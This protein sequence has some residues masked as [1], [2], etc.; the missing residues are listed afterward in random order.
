[1][2]EFTLNQG[3]YSVRITPHGTG[4]SS[5]GA[6]ALN[7]WSGDRLIDEQGFFLYLRD[8]E[9]SKA[10][11]ATPKPRMPGAGSHQGSSWPD[12][13]RWE[14][15]F[16]GTETR[17]D[18][19]CLANG[20]GEVR[21]LEVTNR[22]GGIREIE[23]TSFLEV[24]LHHPEAD[25]NHPAFQKLF[26]QTERDLGSSALLAHRR[27]RAQDESWPWLIHRLEGA[28][29]TQWETSR[30][31]F[32]GRG[33]DASN[34][35]ALQ[36]DS[37]LSNLTGKVLDACFSLRC[38][39]TLDAGETRT[40]SFLLG[41]AESREEA[42]R[43]TGEWTEPR[44]AGTPFLISPLLASAT[45]ERDGEATVPEA[46]MGALRNLSG[47]GGFAPDGNEYVIR[48]PWEHGQPRRTPM[49]WSNCIANQRIGMLVTESGSVCTWA[50]NSQANRLTP[51]SNDPVTDPHGEALY[52]R[53]EDTGEFWSPL[54]GPAPVPAAY[55]TRHG[56]GYSTF[57][58][59]WR[60]SSSEIDFFVPSSMPVR[61]V[62]WRLTNQGKGA[63]RFGFYG[64]QRLVLGTLPP[65]PGQLRV[66]LFPRQA[67]MTVAYPQSSP[68]AGPEVFATVLV[69]D[70]E[71]G[72][73]SGTADRA[74]FLGRD[75]G[76]MARPA[77][78]R[79]TGP[80][81]GEAGDGADACFGQRVEVEVEPGAEVEVTFL[82]GECDPGNGLGSLPSL[83]HRFR[84]PGAAATMLA[85]VKEVWRSMLGGIQV[86]T[87]V[88]S[89]D[90]MLNGWLSYQAIASRLIGR[91]AFY[92]SSGAYGFRDQLQDAHGLSMLW[93]ALTRAQIVRNA[94]QQ[95]GEGDVMHWWHPEPISRG[96][97]TRFSDDLLWLPYVTASYAE[98]T[99][100]SSIWE[101]EIPFL[102][103][104]ELADGQDE[105]Y[106]DAVPSGETGTI[107]EHCCRAIDRSLRTGRHGLP[108][109]GTGD[110]NDGMN[111]VGR[112]GK[113]ESIWMAFFLAEVLRRMVP[114]CE[115]RNEL[116]RAREYTKH[117]E[118][119]AAAVEREG[120]DG[121]WYRRAY[122]DNGTPLG[123]AESPECQIDS[124]A[125]SWAVIS[126][127]GD[128]ARAKQGMNSAWERLLVRE[129]GLVRL[130]SPPFVS[131]PEDPGYIKGY[132]AGVR[133]NGGQYTHAA[134]WFVQA[135]AMAG[136][137]DDAAEVL[138][139]LTPV[140]HTR[141]LEATERYMVEPYVIAADVYDGDPLT[142]RGGWTWYTG[143]AAW[144]YRVA[145][146]TVLG[147]RIREGR[148]L[149]L[150]PRV[151]SSWPGFELR[152]RHGNRGTVY[153]IQANRRATQH[154]VDGRILEAADDGL[155]ISIQDDGR[156]HDVE[157]GLSIFQEP[158]ESTRKT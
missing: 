122:Y 60:D 121:E 15:S 50:R 22:S 8:V 152:Y 61:V 5:L 107:F 43:L 39:L 29:V 4:Q 53:D 68:F 97:R 81:G 63:R 24:V 135:L 82:L 90:L 10:W 139:W 92:Q 114:W 155:T 59:A 6:V 157:L 38:L 2:R 130:L 89:L 78:L 20:Q 151:P 56:W 100:D 70:A 140:W 69:N 55:E 127:I 34:P 105:A 95:F 65:A 36:G 147:F 103:G 156:S 96:M 31:R 145:L 35:R 57:R 133:E 46:Y 137:T 28:P 19:A 94:R 72:A 110:W 120:W 158:S 66:K 62:R 104:Q 40:L 76:G 48:L 17:L 12:R 83:L 67:V 102:Q 119:L 37:N 132:V 79:E 123:S 85:E 21:R 47:Y 75:G 54:P 87:P 25:A 98:Q 13:V 45:A 52:L 74:A 148:E 44:G 9:T 27:A 153:V 111:R 134:C 118:T 42:L 33:R 1:M 113:G 30:L 150:R 16:E 3:S 129:V 149:V 138:E 125:Q 101:E 136:R 18:V 142:G 141:S 115:K 146:E 73:W 51:W 126:G 131:C 71:P 108:L 26:I 124:L 109:M 128:P 11:S 99:G 77:A 84:Q 117:R 88:M 41:I 106:V 112:E 32:L 80:L 143:S 23:V 116:E 64:F 93:P 49:P 7:R 58:S 144:F 14:G 91:T 86:E 154:T